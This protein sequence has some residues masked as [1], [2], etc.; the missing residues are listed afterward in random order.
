MAKKRFPLSIVVQAVDKISAPFRK[1]NNRL[2]TVTNTTKKMRAQ[3]KAVASENGLG[4]ALGNIK[5]IGRSLFNLK[6]LVAGGLLGKLAFGFVKTGDEVAKTASKLG[7]GIEFLQKMQFAGRKT[8]VNVETMN[9]A[10]QRFG[11]RVGEAAAGT[12]E[13]R[14]ALDALG[15]SVFGADGKV[16]KLDSLMPEVADKLSKIENANVRN[17]LAMKF[18]DSEGVKLVNTL[19]DGSKGLEE[20]FAQA[21]KAGLITEKQAKQSEDFNDAML[22]LSATFLGLRN[23]VIAPL[24]PVLTELLGEF[25]VWLGENKEQIKDWGATTAKVAAILVG[26]KIAMLIWNIG[27]ALKALNATAAANPIL[28]LIKTFTLAYAAGTLLANFISTKFPDA[29]VT[30]GDTIGP[31]IDKMAAG[32]GLVGRFLGVGGG[33]DTGGGQTAIEAA[34]AQGGAQTNNAAV[35]VDFTGEPP[36]GTRISGQADRDM[37]FNLA[38]QGQTLAE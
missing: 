35:T 29:W 10:M 34:A 19:K 22:D 14:V 27:I 38:I 20:Y 12:G 31:I 3:F 36:P 1:I 7:V 24:I 2:K 4:K 37:Q 8:G 28:A 18:F 5:G 13:A 32:V 26:G 23:E 9:M 17:A 33:G 6:S 15:I 25:T 16:R 21:T 30:L 11:R